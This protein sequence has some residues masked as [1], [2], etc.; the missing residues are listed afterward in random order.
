MLKAHERELISR[1]L[2]LYDNIDPERYFKVLPYYIA[3]EREVKCAQTSVLFSERSMIDGLAMQDAMLVTHVN[4]TGIGRYR[5]TFN[6]TNFR[7]GVFSIVVNHEETLQAR[8]WHLY[9]M[10][11]K[12][13][14]KIQTDILLVGSK[15]LVL[16]MTFPEPMVTR[17]VPTKITLLLHGFLIQNATVLR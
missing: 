6:R 17:K 13:A 12:R 7:N 14:H 15:N 2:Y 10:S 4:F 3:I 9:R 16:G 11:M 5:E 8:G 1:E